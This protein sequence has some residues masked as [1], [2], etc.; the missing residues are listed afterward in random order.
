MTLSRAAYPYAPS[1]LA[2]RDAAAERYGAALSQLLRAQR[3]ARAAY[4]R[5]RSFPRRQTER[6]LKR[7]TAEADAAFEMLML[8]AAGAAQ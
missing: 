3:A 6:R 8:A 5:G 7:A 4:E 2:A 1:P